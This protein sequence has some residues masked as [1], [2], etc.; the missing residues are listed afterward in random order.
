MI[1]QPDTNMQKKGKKEKKAALDIPTKDAHPHHA[2]H[3]H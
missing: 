1:K 2:Q 3:H